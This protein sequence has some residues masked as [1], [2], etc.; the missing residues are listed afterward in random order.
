[1]ILK[2]VNTVFFVAEAL[3]TSAYD[4]LV[5]SLQLYTNQLY[6][7]IMILAKIEN[8]NRERN[9]EKKKDTHCY[10]HITN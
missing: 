2:C 4:T 8:K 5:S 7:I 1:M 3:Y 9:D 6:M 10:I